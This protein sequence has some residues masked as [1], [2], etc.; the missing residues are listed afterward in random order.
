M[1]VRTDRHDD[2]LVPQHRLR[3]A[4]RDHADAE[5]TGLIA[6]DDVDVRESDVVLD[7]PTKR[8]AAIA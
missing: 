3:N 6:F 7:L 1:I 4:R 2:P 8:L 5:L